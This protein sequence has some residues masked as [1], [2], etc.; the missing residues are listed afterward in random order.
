MLHNTAGITTQYNI[1]CV[2][3]NTH[4]YPHES[5]P[6]TVPEET[7]TDPQFGGRR[8]GLGTEVPA[9]GRDWGGTGDS[10]PRPKA[11]TETGRPG[12]GQN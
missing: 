10:S 11:R 4:R 7:E 12:I 9:E 1:I 3:P 2:I 8:P 6:H 5:K